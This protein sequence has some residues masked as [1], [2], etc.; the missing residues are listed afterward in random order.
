MI[1]MQSRTVLQILKVLILMTS[2]V[3]ISI[4]FSTFLLLVRFTDM[5]TSLSS[6]YFALPFLFILL[7]VLSSASLITAVLRL[8][9]AEEYEIFPEFFKY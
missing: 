7:V 4:L 6:L 3:I 5:V 9:S 8:H 2:F 1:N